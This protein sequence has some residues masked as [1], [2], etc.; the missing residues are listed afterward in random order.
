MKS[1]CT[2]LCLPLSLPSLSLHPSLPLPLSSPFC[3]PH[4]LPS[5]P[6]PCRNVA[7]WLV[8]KNVNQFPGWVQCLFVKNFNCLTDAGKK[9]EYMRKTYYN[10]ATINKV[11]C[12]TACRP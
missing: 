11:G 10:N 1:T 7:K 8:M 6:S 4:S 3:L 12:S 2:S 9:W 5:S